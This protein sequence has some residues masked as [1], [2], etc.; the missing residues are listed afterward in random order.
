MLFNK[1]YNNQLISSS[2]S[3][4]LY[5]LFNI[6]INNKIIRKYISTSIVLNDSNNK[7]IIP[8]DKLEF[9]FARAS[10]PGGQNV[11]KLN[12]KAE[13]RFNVASAD[14]IPQDVKLRLEA[15]QSNRINKDGDL[16]ITS[17]EQRFKV[18]IIF[19]FYICT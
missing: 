16:I 11:N 8:T 9:S 3:K 1:L 15:Y 10:G 19:S 6:N 7:L 2:I 12:T 17:Q 14:W 18:F 13:L 4:S 5:S